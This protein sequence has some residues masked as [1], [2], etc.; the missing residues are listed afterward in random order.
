MIKVLDSGREVTQTRCVL[1]LNTSAFL[2]PG[3][4]M[5][6]GG[7]GRIYLLLL[8]FS[9]EDPTFFNILSWKFV[10]TLASLKNL[11]LPKNY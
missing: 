7:Q 11:K 9:L 1:G 4:Y 3:V 10:N 5:S 2:H 8:L 6:T